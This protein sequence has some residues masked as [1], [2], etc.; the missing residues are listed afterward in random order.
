MCQRCPGSGRLLNIREGHFSI[1]LSLPYARVEP[2]LPGSY[3]A[4][5]D[6]INN[7][8]DRVLTWSENTAWY[9][10]EKLE[11]TAA[12]SGMPPESLVL[13]G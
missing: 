11:Q 6:L 5:T 9:S 4:Y 10:D 3:P 8:N 13:G 2:L 1:Y 7:V 12:L